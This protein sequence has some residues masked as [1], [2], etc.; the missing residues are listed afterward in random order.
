[1]TISADT[2][3]EIRAQSRAVFAINHLR[4]ARAAALRIREVESN[5]QGAGNGE[6]FD[7]IKLDASTVVVMAIAALEAYVGEV[8]FDPEKNFPSAPPGIARAVMDSI[9]GKA[10][11]LDNLK[12]LCLLV[13]K[14][15]DKG[16]PVVQRVQALI[17]LRNELVHYKPDWSCTP[18]SK[19]QKIGREIEAYA[20]PTPFHPADEPWLPNRWMSYGSAKW[21]VESVRD[22][23]T[24][25][26]TT[27]GWPSPYSDKPDWFELP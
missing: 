12:L 27:N 13:N 20:I 5:N 25:L 16:S 15:L 2:K 4:T 1:M 23:V 26:A 18:G 7:R 17:K 14:P 9:A 3:I 21:A 22:L 10:S 6:H 19:H 8:Q 24:H 11:I